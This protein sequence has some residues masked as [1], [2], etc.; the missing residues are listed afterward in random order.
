ME[1]GGEVHGGIDD[2]DDV[3]S[4]GVTFEVVVGSQLGVH[5]H[6]ATQWCSACQHARLQAINTCHTV[7]YSDFGCAENV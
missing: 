6:R 2:D 3:L 5:K 7:Y 1:E 4:V